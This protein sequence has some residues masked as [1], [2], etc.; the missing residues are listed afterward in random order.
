MAFW[1]SANPARSC[2]GK[3]SAAT[4]SPACSGAAE[5]M[6]LSASTGG[7]ACWRSQF[8]PAL[9]PIES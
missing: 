8:T 5:M 9:A 6:P 2:T 1:G 3:P 4:A 7:R